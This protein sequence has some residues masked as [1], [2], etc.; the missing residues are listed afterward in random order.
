M[1]ELRKERGIIVVGWDG[2]GR[3]HGGGGACVILR[4]ARE[5]EGREEKAKAECGV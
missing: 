5:K 1:R 3:L 4:R 2:Q